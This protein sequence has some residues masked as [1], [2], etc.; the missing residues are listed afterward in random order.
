MAST[1]LEKRAAETTAIAT[2]KLDI[3]ALLL[4]ATESGMSVDGL[5]RLVA[6]RTQL[7]AEA[8]REAFFASLA[9]FQ[10]K[11]P[12]IEK[13]EIVWQKNRLHV[14]DPKKPETRENVRYMFAPL[15]KIEEAIAP[16]CKKFGFSY[17]FGARVDVT[18]GEV[19]AIVKVHHVAGHTEIEEFP[20]PIAVD[21]Y[22]S[23]PQKFASSLSFS[24]R[25]ALVGAFGLKLVGD[26]NDGDGDAP[27][28]RREQR[29][30]QTARA[31]DEGQQQ[32]AAPAASGRRDLRTQTSAP[33][34]MI[35][36][37]INETQVGIIKK[38]MSAA[39]LTDGDFHKRFGLMSVSD[40][41]PSQLQAALDWI[42]DPIKN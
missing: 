10:A 15:E 5:E 32:G 7:K 22:M 29:E 6:L 41:A 3:E 27:P 28:E 30:V 17:T 23:A 14:Y 39:S 8:A 21:A 4:K 34:Q 26:D 18:A 2:H 37:K 16:W 35:G 42:K 36:E 9:A 33:G 13:T 24:K 20:V 11:C 40:L 25:Y 19:A 38:K 31:R 1:A 12:P